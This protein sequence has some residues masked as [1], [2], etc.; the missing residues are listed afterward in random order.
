MPSTVSMPST[1][2]SA[3]RKK[4]LLPYPWTWDYLGKQFKRRAI[5]SSVKGPVH[6][7]FMFVDHYEPDA[8]AT[9][10]AWIKG[11]PQ[12]AASHRDADGRAP[13]YN[14]F[15]YFFGASAQTE[16]R[17]LRDLSG[18]VFGGWGE[19]DLHL[20]HEED[21]AETLT[22]DLYRRLKLSNE[23]GA[24]LSSG[25][26]PKRAYG[27]IHG[28]WALDNSRLGQYCGV[29]NE[30]QV[31]RQTGCFADYT[32]AA[33]GPMQSRWVN[34]I[35]MAT[36]DPDK[37]KSYDTGKLVRTGQKLEGD[38]LMVQGP[39]VMHWDQ[40]WKK[41]RPIYDHGDITKVEP[42]SPK[43]LDRWV[44]QWIHVEGRPEWVFVKVYTHGAVARDMPVLLGPETEALFSDLEKRYNDGKR[45]VLHYVTA[46]EAYN[47]IQAAADGKTGNPN[48]YR[49]YQLPPPVNRFL[50]CTS[51]MS[52][53]AC[54]PNGIFSVE[55][56]ENGEH[57]LRANAWGIRS[58]RGAISSISWRQEFQQ[59]RG[60][61]Q[62]KGLG[63]ATVEYGT[64]MMAINLTGSIHEVSIEW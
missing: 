47:I 56:L 34:S 14:W 43:R 5:A 16:A 33:W 44:K 40:A 36:D 35:Y 61:L 41:Q 7:M 3:L 58:V 28:M 8:Q 64:K 32:L 23:Y 45:F 57:T 62:L 46:R 49:N 2:E 29:N 4:R 15:W 11:F 52:V 51:R 59:R 21:T 24:M 17:F 13:Q 18:L 53:K 37:P 20:H 27:F 48:D 54:Q 30:L 26:S 50:H 42:P 60:Q 39:T 19:V 38:L 55:L 9:V 1:V 6:L 22:Q 31:L 25:L 63:L 10:D 12:M